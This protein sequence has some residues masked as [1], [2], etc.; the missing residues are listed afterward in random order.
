MNTARIFARLRSLPSLGSTALLLAALPLAGCGGDD[1]PGVLPAPAATQL[2]A[3]STAPV[4]LPAPKRTLVTGTLTPTR[5]QNLLLDPG[6]WLTAEGEQGS[7]TFIA[8]YAASSTRLELSVSTRSDSPAGF[9]GGVVLLKDPKA[10]DDKSRSIQLIA[11]FTGGKG[12]FDVSVWVSSIDA[13]GAP[14]PFPEDGGGFEATV[15]DAQQRSSAILKQDPEKTLT[16][17]KR[18]WVQFRGQLTKDM[19][20]GGLISIETGTK[21]GGF[22][23]A[24]PEIVALP[25]LTTASTSRSRRAPEVTWR[26]MRAD[27]RATFAAYAAIPRQ[28][29]PAGR[30]EP[31][32]RAPRP[33]L[34][35]KKAPKAR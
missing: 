22:E 8:F 2:P 28:Y 32:A 9:G 12:P 31:N 20:G 25:T 4:P 14:R 18:T 17:G 29:V 35:A 30:I 10:T 23:A 24:S 5:A 6:F 19:V 16:L 27:E 15:A 33:P 34:A 7:G 21:G 13:A 3:P 1:T 11:G 26:P